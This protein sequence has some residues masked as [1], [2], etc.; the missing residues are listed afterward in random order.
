MKALLRL[1]FLAA[2]VL[3]GMGN[4]KGS[5]YGA[6]ILGYIEVLVVTL[7][8]QGSFLRGVVSLLA[9]VIVLIIKPEGL[10]GVVFE[11]ERL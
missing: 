11:E 5:V 3:G 2:V 9:M 10:F 8:P 6:F 7:L 1:L 4:I